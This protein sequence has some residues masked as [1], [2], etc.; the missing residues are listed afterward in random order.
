MHTDQVNWIDLYYHHYKTFPNFLSGLCFSTFLIHSI[1]SYFVM[2]GIRL[3][4]IPNFLSIFNY[5][6]PTILLS[7]F[8][9]SSS[10]F[11]SGT[12]LFFFSACTIFL[13][14]RKH[15]GMISHKLCLLIDWFLQFIHFIFQYETWFRM[16]QD[17]RAKWQGSLRYNQ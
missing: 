9:R 2:C 6:A 11:E 1:Y 8:L 16:S 10:P 14:Y 3:I 13:S 5:P 12:L 7:S 17:K 4:D 15:E